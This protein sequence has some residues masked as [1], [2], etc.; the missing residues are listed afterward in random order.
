MSSRR[1]F[2]GSDDILNN[3]YS[4]II[5]QKIA[6][7]LIHNVAESTNKSVEDVEA[8]IT[9]RL[10]LNTDI[11][12]C[13]ANTCIENARKQAANTRERSLTIRDC[14]TS[15]QQ[16]KL[17]DS[18]SMFNLQFT[19][20]ETGAHA[21]SRAHRVC[22]INFM[23][24]EM[25]YTSS[26]IPINGYDVALKDVGG[27]PLVHLN[28]G[29]VNVHTCFPLMD[30]ADNTR[31]CTY[32]RKLRQFDYRRKSKLV[33]DCYKMHIDGHP[34][35]ICGKP[36]QYC[37]CKSMYII[38]VHSIYNIPNDD[39]AMIMAR[40]SALYAMGC[41]IFDP[42]ILITDRGTLTSIQCSYLKFKRHGTQF[43]RFW[44]ENDVQPSYEHR[45]EDYIQLIRTRSI[46]CVYNGV[47]HYYTITPKE[48]KNS[49]MFFSIDE[50]NNGF[51]PRSFST[52]CYTC[53]ELKNSVVL[54]TYTWDT[55][56]KKL[57]NDAS[58]HM[59]PVR[60]IVPKRMFDSMYGYAIV[61]PDGKLTV[62]NLLTAGMTFNTREI[63]NG[64]SVSEFQ[65][66]EP[67]D[68]QYLAYAIFYLTY[69]SQYESSK[70][71]S[72]L[73]S[74]EER[75][76]NY[77]SRSFLS[78][79]IRGFNPL[80]TKPE[81]HVYVNLLAN[82]DVSCEVTSKFHTVW[83]RFQSWIVSKSHQPREYDVFVSD[84][85]CRF[86]T[87]SEE[88][89]AIS[90]P[91]IK[92]NRGTYNFEVQ[93][94]ISV[95]QV[96]EA[97][98][99]ELVEE[100]CPLVSQSDMVEQ[101]CVSNNLRLIEN[102][103]DGDC[104][105]ISLR[106]SQ[107]TAETP[108]VIRRRLLNSVHINRLKYSDD[109]KKNLV[110]TTSPD[111]YGDEN[112]FL[113]IAM[114]YQITVCVHTSMKCHRYGVGP[115]H[116]FLVRN[117]HCSALVLEY[118]LD[119][120]EIEVLD[121]TS[122]DVDELSEP[123]VSGVA[124]SCPGDVV[125]LLDRVKLHH[126]R[127]R[128]ASSNK[129]SLNRCAFNT[130]LYA[131]RR[132]I[133]DHSF[134]ADHNELGYRSRYGLVLKE[135][136]FRYV[137][138]YDIDS[139]FL[140]TGVDNIEAF[141]EMI[142]GRKYVYS[143]NVVT[144]DHDVAV[145]QNDFNVHDYSDLNS[146][147]NVA[148]VRNSFKDLNAEM[149]EL[150]VGTIYS[151]NPLSFNIS[152]V[153]NQHSFA[154]QV[155]LCSQV[156]K[157][158]H[159][160]LFLVCVLAYKKIYEIFDVLSDMFEEVSIC[161]VHTM[162]AI[163]PYAAVV[164]RRRRNNLSECFSYDHL[165]AFEVDP[166]RKSLKS[167]GSLCSYFHSYNNYYSHV[168]T[169]FYKHVSRAN[170]QHQTKLS[171]SEYIKSSYL[172]LL[173]YTG[174]G[175]SMVSG[176]VAGKILS[177][178][179]SLKSVL[180]SSVVVDA[181]FYKSPFI[182]EVSSVVSFETACEV[183]TESSGIGT[184]Y[185]TC[186]GDTGDLYQESSNC[187]T[188]IGVFEPHQPVTR[189]LKDKLYS[190][191]MSPFEKKKNFH[192]TLNKKDWC[193]YST[194]I[195]I[196]DMNLKF[197]VDSVNTISN[198]KKNKN[199]D[200]DP[201]DDPL[202]DLGLPSVQCDTPC[203][204]AQY[205]Y[206]EYLK[207]THEA[208]VNN[209]KLFVS[210]C[211]E[212]ASNLN[213]IVQE[214]PG[215]FSIYDI[216]NKR[217]MVKSKEHNPA[218]KYLKYFDSNYN[219]M[220]FTS[221][222]ELSDIQH[223][224][225]VRGSSCI[226]FNEYCLF[227][228]E[229]EI[230]NNLK[231]VYD[232]A[233]NLPDDV[234]I[235]QAGPGTGKTTH[236]IKNHSLCTSID[237]STVILSTLEGC[238][239]FRRRV[240][241]FYNC[242]ETS[243]FEV[244]YRTLAS[245][246][247]NLKKNR[248]TS[249]LYI[250]EALM[251]HPGSLFFAIKLSGA[252][253]VRFLGDVL[254]IPFV[255]RTPD[256]ECKYLD[257]ASFVP[258]SS[259]LDISYRCPVDIAWR[260]NSEYYAINSSFGI[261]KGLRSTNAKFNS[262]EYIKITNIND[263]P[264]NRSFKYLTFTHSDKDAVRNLG[265]DVSTVHEF[266]GKE[267]DTVVVVRL[268]QYVQEEI[269]KNFSYALVALTRHRVR[270]MYYTRVDTDAL[271]T[272]IKVNNVTVSSVAS[273]A[274]LKK[275]L[276][277]KIG[278]VCGSV[279]YEDTCLFDSNYYNLV[280]C[281]PRDLKTSKGIAD[282]IKKKFIHL[283]CNSYVD[284]PDI[285][286][287]YDARHKRFILSI[288]MKYDT[289]QR[290]TYESIYQSLEQL[291][292]VC[293]R[294]NLS[295]LHMPKTSRDLD[296]FDWHFVSDRLA[297]LCK[298]KK[299]CVVVHSVTNDAAV[300]RSFVEY[301]VLPVYQVKPNS[302][303]ATFEHRTGRMTYS[304]HD[305]LHFVPKRGRYD[306]NPSYI[307]FGYH[308]GVYSFN[309]H[310]KVIYCIESS[311]N[312]RQKP[313][314]KYIMKTLRT[315]IQSVKSVPKSFCIDSGLFDY[316]EPVLVS[317]I[318]WK[319]FSARVYLY[320]IAYVDELESEIFSLLNVNATIEIPNMY[321]QQF[322]FVSPIVV[323][324]TTIVFPSLIANYQ[325]LIDS[326]FFE[327]AYIDQSLDA[328]LV[329]SS[330]LVLYSGDYRYSSLKGLYSFPT[331][332]TMSPVLKTPM[333][334]T[335]DTTSREIRLALEKRNLAVPRMSGI[336]DIELVADDMLDRFIYNCFDENMLRFHNVDTLTLSANDVHFWLKNQETHVL[337]QIVPDFCLHK[338]AIDT[339]NFSIK[340][341]PKP[342]L[343]IDATRS[344]AALQTIVY[345]EKD[346][347]AM[348]CTQFRKIKDRM[349]ACLLPHVMMYCD[350][351][352]AEFSDKLNR[353]HYSQ[354][355]VFSGDDSYLTDGNVNLEIDISKYDKSQGLLALE[356]DCRVLRY[357]GMP[358]YLIELWYYGHYLTKVYDRGTSLRCLIPFQR[359]SGDASTF[360]LNTA[361]LMGVISHEIPIRH[362]R[363]IDLQKYKDPMKY[364]LLFNLEVKFF[365]YVY[366]YFCSKF[367]IKTREGWVFCPDPVKLL[368]KLG[369]SDLVNDRHVEYYRVSFADNVE[370]YKN[371]STCKAVSSA[372]QERY[373]LGMDITY[374][375][376]S[377]PNIACQDNFKNFFFVKPGSRIDDK[378]YSFV[379]KD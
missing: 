14:L 288:G 327:T 248:R 73:L 199:I 126:E 110:S 332:D 292:I 344:Y 314:T 309:R 58:S 59:T 325:V 343:T 334:F 351:S 322:S 238:V 275:L 359:K 227:G 363:N 283:R 179:N 135:M 47:R 302:S 214:W 366:P 180:K 22:E 134:L 41:F 286:Y 55:I 318:L 139:A 184:P 226:I 335:R 79:F 78:R 123:H 57:V 144:I 105:Y 157:P 118:R 38:F 81:P 376:N 177:G 154:F 33:R 188:S 94:L 256:F 216:T 39:I 371:I 165:A 310:N 356:F 133:D 251:S 18:F 264:V 70:A 162:R 240:A 182:P 176:S 260:L 122:V 149:T 31:H 304:I 289:H 194:G 213:S 12:N 155:M 319:F 92:H 243:E 128:L 36:A 83:N 279:I 20:T 125:H 368:V 249:T 372:A 97:M 323:K 193:E 140:T 63:I 16:A 119:E 111:N 62:K 136:L 114:E 1:P 168:M 220:P 326:V 109:V 224:F 143:Y 68:V 205:E 131:A 198:I 11:Q 8:R 77:E 258:I 253:Y 42:I 241:R 206:M 138:D 15:A 373:S 153:E 361:F 66:M 273:D 282:V 164:C 52:V 169:L 204:Y 330:D 50:A 230:Y 190:F 242:D 268:N 32:G 358:E 377:F 350:M 3:A 27:N 305:E 277:T 25:G 245:Y 346:I 341:H 299:I 218:L 107:V 74:S 84:T 348:F 87:I 174:S 232:P 53:D 312:H 252:K 137:N 236:I 369:R 202:G 28:A 71:M 17:Q 61:L 250:D 132:T 44:F 152:L 331:F 187:D 145:V 281:V 100:P 96:K 40:S 29:H 51:I 170:T 7:H 112:N 98:F 4:G 217:F 2:A 76:R 272:L 86:L 367:L 21:F 69:V 379:L 117:E 223:C 317:S 296:N 203:A 265:L 357:F 244:Y 370:C 85:M 104:I 89:D 269:F 295:M 106:D 115:L 221:F 101:A 5:T 130:K 285:L 120:T 183:I 95:E 167:Y 259:V 166:D 225:L 297:E 210:R 276:V 141:S 336:I 6:A 261:N 88:L 337:S 64:T 200:V 161:Q 353:N 354:L 209:V 54:Y 148:F 159:D 287:Q 324:S 262:A 378:R 75:L 160:A 313:T 65:K 48:L 108:Q 222:E 192:I 215:G 231:N 163:N 158:G 374:I 37:D 49:V 342:N 72:H 280:Y 271:S 80:S 237:P 99:C 364:A 197:P 127:E 307:P 195:T 93:D 173:K 102:S 46:S 352:P 365:T 306:F 26:M 207:A 233:W 208:S 228:F 19:A 290:P 91:R 234:S 320:D 267:H 9:E 229:Q 196:P 239:D 347:N 129:D 201:P 186:L 278:S 246:L 321:V 23:Y 255:N 60:V 124:C 103:S 235:I 189:T 181:D 219:L 340:R 146:L 151:Y 284:C 254:Q 329:H 142:S 293:R 212:N 147:N 121:Q 30:I 56:G 333:Y 303:Y 257:L 345:H 67:R 211:L 191:C 116:H 270:C 360:I 24:R 375:L 266:Q 300:D 294:L 274:E 355:A 298:K 311:E 291:F 308:P 150:F 263:V 45:Y 175:D 90:A 34:R 339:Y 43:I 178:F 247:L 10:L 113:L 349:T 13:M 316:I 328:W 172:E 315:H 185:G 156:L 338:R 301:G 82:A 362:L 35:V 171:V